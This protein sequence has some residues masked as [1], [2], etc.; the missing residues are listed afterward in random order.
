MLKHAL[1]EH[2][3]EIISLYTL[4]IA[5][6]VSSRDSKIIEVRG[7]DNVLNFLTSVGA[8]ITKLKVYIM[9]PTIESAISNLIRSQ[10][11]KN[12]VHIEIESYDDTFFDEMTQPFKRAENVTIRSK[13]KTVGN[14]NLT[15]AELFPVLKRLSLPFTNIAD[16]NGTVQHLPHLEHLHVRVFSEFLPESD[17]EKMMIAN[18]Q[19]KSLHLGNIDLNFLET[20]NK[21]LPH[22]ESLELE[23]YSSEKDINLNNEICFENVKLLTIHLGYCEHPRRIRF[24]NLIELHADSLESLPNINRGNDFLKQTKTIKKLY[25]N[26]RCVDYEQLQTLISAQLN[27]T[28]VALKLCGDITDGHIVEYIKNNQ[29]M[30]TFKLTKNEPMESA[31]QMIWRLF[32]DIWNVTESKQ[33]TEQNRN[34]EYN[35]LIESKH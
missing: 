17:V 2:L 1:A 24:A 19:I 12:V 6:L 27:L 3:F 14:T 31:A 15:F 9:D 23:S 21:V 4:Q 13:Y 33:R 8:S 28:E 32:A 30:E 25:V 34:Y 10:C 22:L 5:K 29:Q 20:V 11:A 18:P 26:D 16:K 35:L 7:A